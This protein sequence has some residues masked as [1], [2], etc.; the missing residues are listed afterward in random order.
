MRRFT[1][2]HI[3]I[4]N[5]TRFYHGANKA[6]SQFDMIKDMREGKLAVDGG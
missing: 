4:G 6:S 2:L 1:T 3:A 5:N